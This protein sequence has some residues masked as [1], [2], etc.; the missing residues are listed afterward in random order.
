MNVFITTPQ[1]VSFQWPVLYRDVHKQTLSGQ[2]TLLITACSWVITGG[3]TG[4]RLPLVLAILSQI[5]FFWESGWWSNKYW[6]V[7]SC[8]LALILIKTNTHSNCSVFCCFA[9]LQGPLPLMQVQARRHKCYQEESEPT[10]TDG[11]EL[12]WLIMSQ[13]VMLILLF[14]QPFS[15]RCHPDMAPTVSSLTPGQYHAV[16]VY[17]N[18]SS[19]PLAH[20]SGISVWWRRLVV[21]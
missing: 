13:I 11:N 9:C 4:Q 3:Y 12:S 18:K 17:N 2:I 14:L 5:Q 21:D 6:A 10:A 20:E 8:R 1:A 19:G 15:Q 16:T 7:T